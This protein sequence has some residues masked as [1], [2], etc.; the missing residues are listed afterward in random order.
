MKTTRGKIHP[1]G[2]LDQRLT[3]TPA[4]ASELVNMRVT[5][6]GTGWIRDRGWE[7][8]N[9]TAGFTRINAND[10][11]PIYSLYV[12][13]RNQGAE[14]Y[15]LYEFDG[16]LVWE[17]GIDDGTGSLFAVREYL[18]INR[19]PPKVTDPGTQFIPNGPNLII[20]NGQDQ[21][22][23]FRGNKR[24]TP[25]AWQSR[26]AAPQVF[27]PDPSY[28]LNTGG[29]ARR[30][31]SG[32]TALI[33]SAPRGLGSATA[34]T[35]GSEVNRYLY[36]V[37]WVSE[38]G[39]ISPLSDPAAAS[40]S[41]SATAEQHRY[42]PMLRDIDTGPRGTV[43]RIIYRTRNLINLDTQGEAS[44]F[45]HT[46][47]TDNSSTDLID[48]LP[49]SQLIEAAPAPTRTIPVS[50]TLGATFDS[51]VWLT[52]GDG[53][54][55]RIIY[56]DAGKP[57]TFG[58][59]AYIETGGRTGG[60]ITAL[61]S[62]YDALLVFRERSIE[63]VLYAMDGTGY[64]VSTLSADTGTTATNT[65]TEI[66]G[67]GLFFLAH[68]GIY[69]ITGGGD[70]MKL[71]RISDA[72]SPEIRR[73]NHAALARATAAYSPK[74]RE[75]WCHYPADGSERP[76]RGIVFHVEQMRFSLRHAANPASSPGAW[77]FNA[78]ATLPSG[79][80]LLA[81]QTT[82]ISIS[83]SQFTLY[84]RG[85]QV[86]T[87]SGEQGISN[88][89]TVV[90]GSIYNLG[91]DIA[92][93]AIAGIYASAWNDLGDSGTKKSLRYA[94]VEA[95]TRGHNELTL[96]TGYDWRPE[97][98]TAGTQYQAISA[99]VGG[100]SEEAQLTPTA[101]GEDRAFIIGTDT[102]AGERIARMRYDTGGKAHDYW[103]W[104]IISLNVFSVLTHEMSVAV[105]QR[106]TIH[107][108]AR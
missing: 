64:R 20:I 33:V 59:L 35:D 45:F 63:A 96:Q 74:E 42:C 92:G 77:Q 4:S 80:F 107:Q 99:T 16:S 70:E 85:L 46:L 10:V 39:S 9:P 101:G 5:D 43:A 19:T 47:I 65:I 18:D 56:S 11:K 103:R 34:A 91:P 68:D 52:G 86:W 97:L 37:A 28:Y 8:Y 87:A 40:W 62:F 21:P 48:I 23:K 106:G 38:T 41:Y 105:K 83:G 108:G 22:L 55:T 27:E 75:W 7:P 3:P 66:P 73:V 30:N 78:I 79:H 71:S 17:H 69:A 104:R 31:E 89:A 54:E 13:T 61:V 26:P 76:T 100:P 15:P 44:Y 60:A 50:I 51:R 58:E 93:A 94:T 49:D 82:T 90:D 84:N 1:A 88:V 57:E 102:Y 12:W 81:P 24:V 29:S 95:L 53:L 98:F 14:T 67:A 25:Y 36:R 2:G 32:T 72:I 6:E